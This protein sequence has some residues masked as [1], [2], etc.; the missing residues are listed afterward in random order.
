MMPSFFLAETL[1][2]LCELVNCCAEPL[3]APH[4]AA[5]HHMVHSM[6]SQ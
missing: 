5:Q 4:T 3:G 1:K 2:Y 6:I